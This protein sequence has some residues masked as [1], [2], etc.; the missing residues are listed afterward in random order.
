MYGEVEMGS[1]L[2]KGWEPLIYSLDL[3]KRLHSTALKAAGWPRIFLVWHHTLE[4]IT[5]LSPNLGYYSLD[6][7]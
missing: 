2:E 1:P 5:N 6:L 3:F 4:N 7:A